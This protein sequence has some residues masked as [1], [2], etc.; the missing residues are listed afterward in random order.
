VKQVWLPQVITTSCALSPSSLGGHYPKAKI[1]VS[2]KQRSATARQACGSHF[3][4][5]VK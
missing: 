5:K 2:I 4:R 1:N 3:R